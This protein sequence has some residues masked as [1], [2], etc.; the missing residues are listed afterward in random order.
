MLR[1]ASLEKLFT[2][3]NIEQL[4]R[5]NASHKKEVQLLQKVLYVLGYGTAINWDRFGP[6]G[7][8]GSSTAAALDRFYERNTITG[9][10][11]DFVSAST[12]ALLLGQIRLLHYCHYMKLW[13]ENP[14]N[15]D[16]LEKGTNGETVKSVQYLLHN[17]GYDEELNWERFGADGD[18]GN[19]T[20]NAVK[21][22]C[23]QHLNNNDET[24]NSTMG[25]NPLPP[26]VKVYDGTFID[27]DIASVLLKKT[28][29]SFAEDWDTIPY[30]GIDEEEKKVTVWNKTRKRVF[31]KLR[32]SGIRNIGDRGEQETDKLIDENLDFFHRE[33][34]IGDSA[35]CII[36][37]VSANEG[38][39]DA[40]NCY[41]NSFLSF[42]MFQWTLGS[43]NNKGE[44]PALLKKIKEHNQTVFHQCFAQYGIDISDDT[45]TTYGYLTYGSKNRISQSFEKEQFRSP[46]WAFRFWQAGQDENVQAIEVKHAL[47]RL[48]NFYWRKNKINNQYA[49]SDL[50]SSEYGV[51][52]LLDNHVN[53]P[54][55]VN[56]CI[57]RALN[58]NVLGNPENWGT[59]EEDLLLQSY[60]NIRESYGNSPM[61]HAAI[62]AQKAKDARD[63][64]LLSGERGSFKYEH[65]AP[66]GSKGTGFDQNFYP[67]IRD[68][69]MDNIDSVE[70]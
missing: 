20:T 1:L 16:A 54:G 43:G 34:N 62:R 25:E 46:V 57:E 26:I 53:R 45:G 42:G 12:A 10:S 61:T 28:D 59:T 36:K 24:T 56:S 58:E 40:L 66:R 23:E 69:W 35:L 9:V 30:V 67:E 27:D 17:L 33:F 22:F 49:L 63:K 5:R 11:S 52:L 37:V 18:Y 39:L 44:L 55:Y 13:L 32:F 29:L 15:R 14:D 47:E 48:K 65:Q 38:K 70:Y 68:E 4:L 7:G 50:V 51:C 2:Q 6:D 19:G 8:Y 3:N 21:A 41:D 60:L 64:G 31:P